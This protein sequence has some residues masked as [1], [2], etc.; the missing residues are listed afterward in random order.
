MTNKEIWDEAEKRLLELKDNWYSTIG[1][2]DGFSYTP[3]LLNRFGRLFIDNWNNKYNPAIV[4]TVEK[5]VIAIEWD[6]EE[7]D[8]TLYVDLSTLKAE[9]YP[10]MTETCRELD[11]SSG[12]MWAILFG[13]KRINME[14]LAL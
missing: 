5:D 12:S 14:D 8:C 2:E 7:D 11:L 9:F 4:P 1:Y 3:S 6:N 13:V 10:D